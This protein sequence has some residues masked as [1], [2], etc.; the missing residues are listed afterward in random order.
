M[1]ETSLEGLSEE[2]IQHLMEL[3]VIP[4]KQTLLQQQMDRANA[5]RDTEGPQMRGN[6]RVQTAAN[7]LEF[8]VAAY[9]GYQANK[10][11]KKL[12]QQQAAQL[13]K[14]VDGRSLFLRKL[15]PPTAPTS[16]LPPVENGFEGM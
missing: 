2:E 13:Q 15:R 6:N 16:L 10:D 3:G 14:Q 4:S 5:L 9:K 12:E 1:D 7:P 11:V 8:A